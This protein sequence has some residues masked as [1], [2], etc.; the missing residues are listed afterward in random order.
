[1]GGDDTK[2]SASLPW[3]G[4]E[5][6]RQTLGKLKKNSFIALPGKQGKGALLPLETMSQPGG[7]W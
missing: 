5:T 3:G 1:M 6:Q 2:N 7:I 4:I